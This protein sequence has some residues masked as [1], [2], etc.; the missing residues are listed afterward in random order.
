MDKKKI[1]KVAIILGVLLLPLIYSITY[2]KG[3]WD[4]YN[5]L[6]NIKV[7]VVNEDKCEDDCKSDELI[8][9]LKNSDSFDFVLKDKEE[10]EE[11]LLDKKYYATLTIPEDFTFSLESA[12]SKSRKAPIITYRTNKKTNYIASQ[13]IENAVIRVEGKLD[14]EISK[15]IVKTLADKL[16]EVDRKSVV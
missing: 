3:F 12:D 13:L 15:E 4:P 16:N 6:G 2:L 1:K 5:N 8:K 7:A 11:G 14:K 9:E 10:A